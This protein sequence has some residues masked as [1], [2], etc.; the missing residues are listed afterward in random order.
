M[1][2]TRNPVL[3]AKDLGGLFVYYPAQAAISRAPRR[4][5]GRLALVGGDAV[6]AIAHRD[7]ELARRE[8]RLLF[9]DEALPQSED[10]ILR[11]A[12]RQTMF[13]ELEVLR[14]PHL[15][16]ST[17]G[18]VCVIE[19]REHLDAALARGKGAIIL[20][21]HYGAN[22]MIMPALGHTGYPMS[23]LS[24]PPPVW[25]DILRET[26][27][28]PLWEKVLDRRWQLEQRL[29]V[30]HINVFRF[31]RPAFECLQ[32]NEVLG[33]AFDGGGGHRFAKVRLL[34]RTAN[35]SVQPAQLARKTGAV[36]LPTVV[37]RGP[38]ER[39]HRVIIGEALETVRLR[40]REEET[41]RTMQ[42]FVDV[43]SRWVRSHP[44]HY[45]N[46]LLLRYKVRGT[47]VVPFFDDYPPVEGQLD[48]DAAQKHL[49]A[50]AVKSGGA[51]EREG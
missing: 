43:F 19:G 48:T 8:L 33:L 22:Q 31:L 27:T 42:A 4:L 51:D 5:L 18:D 1:K 23:Q 46:F 17:V 3:L 49:R 24:A 2:P 10:D 35:V 39:R 44:A 47:D 28:T 38:G 50:A 7:V 13:N 37:V 16:P 9:G 29:P 25:A 36:I 41:Q 21:G 14:Y 32:K 45:V 34:N 26:R 40:D 6:R 15:N 20:I 30:Q 11:E 12:W